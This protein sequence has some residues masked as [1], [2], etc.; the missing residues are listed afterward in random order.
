MSRIA[1]ED[2]LRLALHRIGR[3]GRRIR[4]G[5]LAGPIGRW[6]TARGAASELIIAPPDLRTAD[7]T[8]A[9]DLYFG[10]FVF[11][12]HAV[13]TE[14]RSPFEVIPPSDDWLRE[15]HGFGWLRHLR[16]ADTPLSRSNA[17]AVVGDWQKL[18]RR[19]AAGIAWEP[20]VAA[21]RALSFLAQSPLI[22][23]DV[24]HAFYRRF[25]RSLVAHA[26]FLKAGI[27][28]IE[29]GLPRLKA[30][31]A[32][33]MVGLSLSRQERLARLG[34][35]RLDHELELQILPDGGHLSRN[36][37]ALV[38][39][40]VDLLPLRQ[41]LIARGQSP[42]GVLLNAVDR[43]MPMLRFFRHGDGSFAHFNG[44]ASSSTGLVATVLSYDETLGGPISS[45][46][47]SGYERV[48]AADGLLLV[49]AGGP[50]PIAYS[51]DAHAGALA[52]EFS[53][54]SRRIVVNCGAPAARHADLRR[55]AR[56][57]AAH[58]TAVLNA[59]SSC[60]FDGPAP[61]ARIVSGPRAVTCRRRLRGDGAT[62]LALSHDGFQRRL[63]LLHQRLLALSA[64]G[65]V[66]EGA[67]AFPGELL[68]EA[69]RCVLRFHLHPAVAVHPTAA[70]DAVELG[71]GGALW[72]FEASRPVAVEESVLLSDVI[73]TRP[74]L[75]L[76]LR[77]AL[78]EMR[79]VAWRL[80]AVA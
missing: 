59:M 11:A 60:R 80:S 19:P 54:G 47:H 31:T 14:G 55:A 69:V 18:F 32:I 49:D 9:G 58:S 50:P 73:G 62:E 6:R 53:S 4:Q 70:A 13:E 3:W 72:R 46:T 29:P 40:L 10:R 68:V 71:V 38:E 7:P 74:T 22:L 41:A 39:A 8:I 64:D 33:A 56:L 2:R 30:A 12:G 21:Q 77:G 5:A 66:L 43:A 42:S 17:R 28:T 65:R 20:S 25:V 75:Q 61:D 78:A 52:F 51:A 1:P 63:G 57:T 27:G 36:P 26:S 76:V 35:E 24:D 44:V 79:S 67:D 16:A 15:L 23:Q 45:A 48:Q 37:A 34:L